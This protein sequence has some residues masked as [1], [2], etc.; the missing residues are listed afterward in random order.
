M[1]QRSETNASAR[2]RVG[3]CGFAEAQSHVYRDFDILEVQRTFYQ[4]PKPTTAAR[5][6]ENAP[7]GFVFTLKAWQL[8]THESSSPTYRRLREKLSD[9]QLAQA[10]GFR[11]NDVTR[12]AWDR[13]QEIAE[14]LSAPVIVF[15]TPKSFKPLPENLERLARFFQRLERDGRRLGFEPRGEA[16]DDGIV[17]NLVTDLDLI[18]VVDPMLRK[19]VGRGLRYY[20][21]H[22]RPGYH[23]HY[24]YTDSDLRQLEASLIKAWPNWILFNNDAMA[25]DARRFLARIR[26]S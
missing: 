16:W 26:V 21:L 11:W 12:M 7:V 5:W 8:L 17:R 22:G 1:I 3:I 2:V 13:T 24:R 23:F 9:T 15:Q 20:R 10:G 6:R 25:T 14:A 18:H 19:P 4:P